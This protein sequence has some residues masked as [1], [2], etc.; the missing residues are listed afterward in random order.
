VPMLA[1]SIVIKS[2]VSLTNSAALNG[3]TVDLPV[4]R[5]HAE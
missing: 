4:G 5:R 2:Y 3:K 1:T